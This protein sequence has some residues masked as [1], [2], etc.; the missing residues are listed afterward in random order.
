MALWNSFLRLAALL[1]SATY[2][3]PP[4]PGVVDVKRLPPRQK[5]RGRAG[6]SRKQCEHSF[7]HLWILTKTFDPFDTGLPAEPGQLPLRIMTDVKLRLLNRAF[8]SS[9]STQV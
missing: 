3:G 9:L 5:R 1:V 7:L 2:D 6:M 4:L 8:Q